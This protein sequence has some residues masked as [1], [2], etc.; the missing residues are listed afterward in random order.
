MGQAKKSTAD[1]PHYALLIEWSEEDQTWIG[2]CPELFMGGVHGVD[3]EKVY[4]E[5][6]Q[7]VDEWIEMIQSDGKEL[8]TSISS[9]EYSGKVKS[10]D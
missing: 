5:L 10:S 4:E 9:R 3:R 6:C 1:R 8:P 7:A 2:R